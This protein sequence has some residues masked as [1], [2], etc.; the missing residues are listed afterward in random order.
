[1]KVAFSCFC[2]VFF[3]ISCASSVSTSA[4]KREQSSGVN[5]FNVLLKPFHLSAD[6][7]VVYF[8]IANNLLLYN[9]VNGEG[10]YRAKLE[11][12]VLIGENKTQEFL[13]TFTFSEHQRPK[14]LLLGEI[15]L[16][17]DEGVKHLL[18][19]KFTDLVRG[20]KVE[21]VI[22]L[23][24]SAGEITQHNFL[25]LSQ[26]TKSPIF[27]NYIANTDTVLI[28]YSS[29]IN[30]PVYLHSFYGNTIQANSPYSERNETWFGNL[31]S[32]VKAVNN[33]E[34]ALGSE[35]LFFLSTDSVSF[36]KSSAVVVENGFPNS[37]S[38]MDMIE[39][40]G[41]IA[42]KE[43]MSQMLFSI[44]KRVDFERFWISKAGSK[45]RAKRLIEE[46]YKRVS[47]ANKVFT[48]YKEG[49]K[50]DKG[51]I[52]LIFGSP[53]EVRITD[54]KEIWVYTKDNSTLPITFAFRKIEDSPSANHYVLQRSLGYK[55]IWHSAVETWR[56]GR[57][58]TY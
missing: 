6:T 27:S 12:E 10:N 22:N 54:E 39:P 46:F 40:I 28:K 19:L 48:S 16:L 11:V 51:M 30:S 13:K 3:L 33:K 17:L 53:D 42:T 47:T 5:N 2:L 58:F 8:Q 14:K 41:Y 26:K 36:Q 38:Y 24:K 1:M 57:Y 31:R 15:P 7:T 21:Y 25:L 45:E 55:M 9:R 34:V 49:W 56:S 29:K 18:T 23:T 20:D 44:N 43:E 35:V 52:Y 37:S 32:E 50:T 4:L